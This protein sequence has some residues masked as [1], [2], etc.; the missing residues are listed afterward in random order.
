MGKVEGSLAVSDY[1]FIVIKICSAV[2]F[3]S[4]YEMLKCLHQRGNPIAALLPGWM[5]QTPKA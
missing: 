4:I 5:G 2:F 3:S 1:G